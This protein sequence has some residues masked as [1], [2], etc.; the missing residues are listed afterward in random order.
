[1]LFLFLP[2]LTHL[3][4][5]PKAAFRPPFGP[6]MLF[7]HLPSRVVLLVLCYATAVAAAFLL[8][9]LWPATSSV[10]LA[11][12]VMIAFGL[13]NSFG[14]IDHGHL[15]FWAPAILAFSG[16][17]NALA[18][19]S[20]RTGE[21]VVRHWAVRLLALVIGLSFL[22]AGYEKW[23]HGWL[24]FDTHATYGYL[25]GSYVINGQ[26]GWLAP[27]AASMTWG[28]AWEVLDW[29]TVILEVGLIFAALN[30]RIWRFGMVLATY[31]HL[32]VL[33]LF[34]IVFAGNVVV[35]GAFFRWGC[36]LPTRMH[37]RFRLGVGSAVVASLALAITAVQMR[38]H[39]VV[40]PLGLALQVTAAAAGTVYLA[41]QLLR[42]LRRQVQ[43]QQPDGHGAL[44]Q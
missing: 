7:D 42:V 43:S 14:K 31:F 20:R 40:P 10:V 33:L 41:L 23:R 16:W 37:V 26:R 44:S 9:G 6:I 18:V 8:F 12:L 22:T 2:L 21:G 28:P 3:S 13:S 29:A 19:G 1:M 25:L 39:G 32:G 4:D 11:T 27:A 15:L 24:D 35:Y 17:G 34:N 36:V 30:W 38:I 5:R